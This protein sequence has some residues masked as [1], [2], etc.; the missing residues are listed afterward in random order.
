[1]TISVSIAD[2]GLQ[3]EFAEVFTSQVFKAT[4]HEQECLGKNT[5]IFAIVCM[6]SVLSD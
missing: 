4:I 6:S 1:M 3:H 5:H 2:P